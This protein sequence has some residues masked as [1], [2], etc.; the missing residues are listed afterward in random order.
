MIM[1]I[2]G[3]LFNLFIRSSVSAKKKKKKKK[4]K[5]RIP[6]YMHVK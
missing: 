5:T 3:S 4:K 6:T 1:M 2:R